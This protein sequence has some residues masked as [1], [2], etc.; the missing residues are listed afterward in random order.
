MSDQPDVTPAR[1]PAE[2]LTAQRIDFAYTVF[3]T[4]TARLWDIARRRLIAARLN[5]LT[6]SPEFLNNAFSRRYVLEGLDDGSAHSG[7]S[8][9]ALQKVLNGFEQS[10]TAE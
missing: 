3:W 2:P 10:E 7:A 8:L 9:L 4:K 6:A 1:K 5:E